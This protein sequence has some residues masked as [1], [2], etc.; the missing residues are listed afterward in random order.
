MLIARLNLVEEINADNLLCRRFFFTK[1]FFWFSEE[2]STPDHLTTFLRSEKTDAKHS[3]AAWARESGKGLLFF[4]KRAEDKPTPANVINLVSNL[5]PSNCT[6]TLTCNLSPM[7]QTSS[8]KDSN[9]SLSRLAPINTDSKL[10]Q[11]RSVTAGWSP[12]RRPSR[13]LKNSRKI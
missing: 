1:H 7:P 13:K 9:S 6:Q 10:P 12:S 5:E 8:R 4:S 2:P 3:S 11:P